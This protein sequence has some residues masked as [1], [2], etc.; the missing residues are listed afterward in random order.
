MAA[1]TIAAHPS[2]DWRDETVGWGLHPN[3]WWFYSILRFENEGIFVGFYFHECI[4]LAKIAKIKPS[5]KSSLIQNGKN[6]TLS[7]ITSS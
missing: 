4:V 5:Q 6:L 1:A 7:H 3:T 2:T